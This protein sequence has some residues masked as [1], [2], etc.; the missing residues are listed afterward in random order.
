MTLHPYIGL[1]ELIGYCQLCH[2]YGTKCRHVKV[3]SPTLL[4]LREVVH[5]SEGATRFL[6]IKFVEI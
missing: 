5:I 1:P 6:G 2:E 4:R 3:D